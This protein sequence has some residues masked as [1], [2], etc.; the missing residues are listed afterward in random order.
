MGTSSRWLVHSVQLPL[1]TS[2]ST[3]VWGSASPILATIGTVYLR[4]ERMRHFD[5]WKSHT[6]VDIVSKLVPE[7]CGQSVGNRSPLWEPHRS[8]LWHQASSWNLKLCLAI[9]QRIFK[10]HFP[11]CIGPFLHIDAIVLQMYVFL[12]LYLKFALETNEATEWIIFSQPTR[13]KNDPVASP[14]G[15][16]MIISSEG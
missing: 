13:E 15:Q 4:G 3:I 9:Y 8:P 1:H 7:P 11:I 16:F 6:H 14:C 10:C 2:L 5:G 12:L